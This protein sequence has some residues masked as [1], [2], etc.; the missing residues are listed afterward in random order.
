M[1]SIIVKYLP[2]TN[3]RPSR[4]VATHTGGKKRV[5]MSYD[6]ELSSGENE[7]RC[8][9]LLVAKLGWN[10]DRMTDAVIDGNRKAF[11]ALTLTNGQEPALAYSC[12][13]S[14]CLPKGV[15]S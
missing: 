7:Y 12:S 15:R 9:A 3:T 5:V 1:Q 4:F 13:V 14:A 8:A 6:Y 2:A 10:W 11:I